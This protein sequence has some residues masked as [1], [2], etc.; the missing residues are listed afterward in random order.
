M[1]VVAASARS[2]DY[3]EALNGNLQN[4]FE[5]AA[6]QIPPRLAHRFACLVRSGWPDSGRDPWRASSSDR[7]FG[8]RRHWRPGICRRSADCGRAY[9]GG[10]SSGKPPAWWDSHRILARSGMAPGFVDL[11][12]HTEIAVADPEATLA[13]QIAQGITTVLLGQDGRSHQPIE[14]FFDKLEMAQPRLNVAF[15][16]GHHSVREAVLGKEAARS[17]TPAEI[18]HMQGLVEAGM[19]CGA[20]GLSTGLEYEPGRSA[21]TEELVALARRAASIGEIYVTH[22]RDEAAEAAGCAGRGAT[23]RTRSRD[24]RAYLSYQTGDAVGLGKGPRD[25]RAPARCPRSR[26]RR[27]RRRLPLLGVAF[28]NR[29]SSALWAV[30]R[31]SEHNKWAGSG[32]WCGASHNHPGLR[33]LTQRLNVGQRRKARAHYAS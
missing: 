27:D 15:L 12:N 20:F 11:H 23:H 2:R 26:D 24:S 28:G 10:W 32:R 1:F 30:R 18:E 29:R 21:A 8:C 6:Q 7:R 25:T 5:G 9:R 14:A 16:V 22:L 33:C 13:T 17:A 19:R 3:G 4:R 31:S